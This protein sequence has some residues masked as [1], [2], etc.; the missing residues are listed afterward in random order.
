MTHQRPGPGSRRPTGAQ[1][2]SGDRRGRLL[3]GDRGETSIQM[4]IVFP[5]VILFTIATVQY[6]VF[7]HARSAAL[8]AAREGVN[9]GRSY[10][11]SP[12]TG[13]ARAQG[14]AARIGGSTL[15]GPSASTA[16]STAETM[17]VTV[18]GTA[19][20][21]LPGVSLRVSQTATGPRERWVAP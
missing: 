7:A 10:Q 16:G 1:G 11:S 14:T 18:S 20:S 13:A 5:F 4:A 2:P 8:T 19:L 17:R 12:G 9:A 3:L 15:R 21:L 6:F